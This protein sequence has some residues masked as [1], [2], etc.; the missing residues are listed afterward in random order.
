MSNPSQKRGVGLS[1]TDESI[2]CLL[3]DNN[4]CIFVGVRIE[5]LKKASVGQQMSNRRIYYCF[6]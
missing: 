6:L 2:C 1:G 4:L 3:M 5:R